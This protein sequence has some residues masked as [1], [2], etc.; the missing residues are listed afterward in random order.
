MALPNIP[1][2]YCKHWYIM[3]S[4]SCLLFLIGI[5]FSASVFSQEMLLS[6]GRVVDSIAVQDT[7]QESFALY[8]PQDFKNDELWPLLVVFDPEGRGRSTAQLFR[9]IG[10]E[11]GYIIAASNENLKQDSLQY[12][13]PKAT[14]LL[15]RLFSSFPI[16]Q[17]QI[18]LAGLEEGA[19]LAASIPVIYN[20]INGVMPV[21][22]AWINPEYI[23]RKNK[24]FFNGMV[25]ER[26][27][28]M[29]LMEEIAEFLAEKSYPSQLNYY[30]GE[31]GEWPDTFELSNA[32]SAFTL[33]AIRDGLRKNDST[34]AIGMEQLFQ[35]QTE[36]AERLRRQRK[37]YQ[38][39]QELEQ[40]EERYKKDEFQDQLKDKMKELRRTKAYR[41][42]RRAYR[43][44]KEVERSKKEMYLNYM[45]YDLVSNNFENV[46]WWAYEMDQLDSLSTKGNEAEV[47][48]ATRLKGYLNKISYEQYRGIQASP[49]K[50]DSKILISVI[51]TVIAKKDPEAYLN[52][53]SLAG[54]DGDYETALLYL[55]DLLKTGYDNMEA[56]YDI[57]GILDL[58][59]SREYNELIEKYLGTSKYYK[60]DL[61]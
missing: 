21:G 29:F 3:K 47:K 37:Y 22:N 46:A 1:Y 58:K 5:I 6:K 11:Q 52:I 9:R 12:N 31:N 59:L 27:P 24:F 25:A 45:E 17:K 54:H 13:V 39:Y 19:Q 40:M 53:I 48:M 61:D 35:K 49:A 34:A 16:D 2:I 50:I 55:E 15:K 57:K 44:A 10:E 14:R 30:E 42:L 26:D 18:Y 32:A 33:N 56:L 41:E 20:D 36:Y 51:R 43:R 8:L 4:R 23:N 38:A 28:D 60:A 7:L